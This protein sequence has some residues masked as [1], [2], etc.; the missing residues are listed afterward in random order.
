MFAINEYLC[1]KS[2]ILFINQSSCVSCE[3]Y[4]KWSTF[5]IV[6]EMGFK[7]NERKSFK[8]I[9]FKSEVNGKWGKLYWDIWKKLLRNKVKQVNKIKATMEFLIRFNVSHQFKKS[10]LQRQRQC[11]MINFKSFTFNNELLK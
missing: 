6:W 10:S 2:F 7:E 1:A 5:P 9:K 4:K 11:W 3:I 8:F